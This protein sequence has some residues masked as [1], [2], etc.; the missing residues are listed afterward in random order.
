MLFWLMMMCDTLSSAMNK[1][2][3][4][5]SDEDSLILQ[6]KSESTTTAAQDRG[7]GMHASSCKD[8]LESTPWGTHF[9]RR[10]EH[11]HPTA[12]LQ[13]PCS[14]EMAARH[15]SDA[16]P[17]KVLLFRKV[18]RL[19]TNL[20]RQAN[21]DK[22]EGA[23]QDALAVYQHWN[24]SYGRFIVDCIAHHEDVPPRIQSWY[25]VLASHWHLAAFLLADCIE[26]IDEEGR[27]IDVYR[28][29]R[30]SSRLVFEIR[31]HSAYQVA[32]LARVGRPRHDSAFHKTCDFHFTLSQ[33]A[34]LTEPWTD[35]LI[36]SFGTACHHFLEWGSGDA[37][38]GSQSI[39]LYRESEIDALY[40][41]CTDCIGAL[42]DLGRKSD[43]AHLAA[44]SFSSRLS[45]LRAMRHG[46]GSYVSCELETN[47]FSEI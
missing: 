20:F 32:D 14:D 36:R 21:P 6:E 12:G 38:L 4:I 31:K 40:D 46:A 11:H 35:V 1:R 23:I 8:D 2:P 42:Q 9:L 28:A 27:G 39:E 37:C 25:T 29:L 43:I 15:L 18:T 24:D 10:T 26:A 30:Q 33:G 45:N 5:V 19:Q 17:V 13:W 47:A 22:L 3:L 44:I 16:A 41:R 34:L 7:F